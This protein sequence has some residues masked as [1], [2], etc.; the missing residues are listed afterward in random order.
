M[1]ITRV[2]VQPGEKTLIEAKDRPA[3]RITASRGMKQWTT[4]PQDFVRWLDKG[5]TEEFAA[6]GEFPARHHPHRFSDQ[7]A[8]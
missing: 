1:R 3:L 6:T 5:T 7:T 4:L 2:T 8:N